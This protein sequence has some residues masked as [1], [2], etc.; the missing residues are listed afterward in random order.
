MNQVPQSVHKD[1][2]SEHSARS[3]VVKSPAKTC[4]VTVQVL[5]RVL[6]KQLLQIISTVTQCHT[7]KA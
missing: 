2:Q 5:P 3:K 7:A 4:N 6:N 1:T